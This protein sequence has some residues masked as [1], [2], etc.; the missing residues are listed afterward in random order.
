MVKVE[1]PRACWDE[2]DMF[3]GILKDQGYLIDPL[4]KEISNQVDSQEY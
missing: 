4:R 1:M 2:I 3:L